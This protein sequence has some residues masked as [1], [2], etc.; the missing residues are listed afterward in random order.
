ML[1]NIHTHT[2]LSDGS[3]PA[4]DYIQSAL[5]AGFTS[6]GFT[7]HSPL[8]FENTF[9]LRE[10]KVQEYCDLI[11]NLK[12]KYE[13]QIDVL[14]GMEVD[15]VPEVGHSPAWFRE[16]FP[17]DFIIGSVHLVK[18]QETGQ[19]WFIDGPLRQS[20]DDGLQKVFRGDIRLGVTT[21]YRQIIGLVK[22]F[23]PDIVGHLDKIKM[24]NQGRY[25]REEEP[26]YVA[27]TEELLTVV[28]EAGCVIEVNTRGIYKKRSDTTFPGPDILRKA[29]ALGIPVTIATDAHKPPEI[30]LCM[31]EAATILKQ[32]GYTSQQRLTATGW[33]EESL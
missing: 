32:A 12:K 2:N 25:F 30:A 4:E 3:Q 8:P 7:D 26:W 6:I 17:L 15:Y 11:L 24:H 9:A 13:G 27:L 18:N 31:P 19:R 20:Y 21:Y 22:L 33:K 14:L 29:Y 5:A 16:H 10:E 23:K 1:S 28:A